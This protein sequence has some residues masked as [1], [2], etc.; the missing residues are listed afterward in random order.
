MDDGIR[1][2]LMNIGD[3]S[4][5]SGL[6]VRM[7][8]HYA[9]RGVLVPAERDGSSGYR[10]YSPA[11]LREAARVRL[12]RDA[13]CGIPVIAELLPLFAEPDAL[14]GRLREHLDELRAQARRIADQQ[15][16][17]S[18]LLG[19]LDARAGHPEVVERLFPAV[20]VLL[21]RRTVADYPAEG[22]LWDG[23]RQ[24]AAA[25]TAHDPGVFGDTVGAT[26][27]DDEYRD[28]DV[29][30]AIWREYRGRTAPEGGY[31]IVELPA[32]HVA[33]VTHRGSFETISEA[34]AAVGTWIADRKRVRTG[35]IF[36]VYVYGP[37]RDP[38]PAT[39]ITEVNVPIAPSAV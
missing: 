16:L 25:L 35:P 8:R 1:A 19:E 10:R 27:Y 30:M 13:G 17:A 26:Y 3:F 28:A 14:R 39:W 36:T 6:S 20:R 32:Q 18:R 22:K 21:L 11:Q 38:D 4:R 9:D 31:E 15:A 34:T 7:L 12:L 23:F 24:P 29:E 5:Y 37:G 33:T 2:P